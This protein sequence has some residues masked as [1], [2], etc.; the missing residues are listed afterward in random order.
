MYESGRAKAIRRESLNGVCGLGRTRGEKRPHKKK[1][2]KG[3]FTEWVSGK[4]TEQKT[5]KPENR[6]TLVQDILDPPP[7][8][9][10]RSW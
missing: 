7:S 10:A 2:E 6:P 8:Q 5:H 4:K 9:S 3:P 1:R